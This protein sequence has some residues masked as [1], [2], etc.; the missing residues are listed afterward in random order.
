VHVI[1]HEHAGV[2][3]AAQARQRFTQPTK[4]SESILLVEEARRPD[5][6]RWTM[7]SGSP[8]MWMRVRRGM[9]KLGQNLSLARMAL[10]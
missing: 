8:P 10:T 7:C 2:Q 4:I 9:L 6:P 5:G 3:R 1:R